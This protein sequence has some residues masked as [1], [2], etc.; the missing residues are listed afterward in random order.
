MLSFK[1]GFT[2]KSFLN[3]TIYV[4]IYYLFIGS[5]VEVEEYLDDVGK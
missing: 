5:Q 2:M 1:Q 4:N 3:T